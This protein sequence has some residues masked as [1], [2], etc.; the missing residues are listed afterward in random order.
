MDAFRDSE[1]PVERLVV[2]GGLVKNQFLMQVYADVTGY[3]LDLLDSAQGP[4]LGAAIHAATAA[5]AYDDVDA[6]SAS[7][8]KQQ[9]NAYL[10][11]PERHRRYDDIYAD[12]LELYEYFGSSSEVLHR[13]RDR[14][15]EVVS[16]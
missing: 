4:A 6:A 5:G 13:L 7:M 10:P 2:A 14:R 1:V 15:D 3:P 16:S 8:G 11:D 9:E 12:Y